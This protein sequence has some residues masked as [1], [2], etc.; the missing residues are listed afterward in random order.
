MN[1]SREFLG[2]RRAENYKE[3]VAD[4]LRSYQALG[5]GMSLRIP[6]FHSHPD[7]FPEHLGDVSDEHGERLYQD[8]AAMESRYHAGLVSI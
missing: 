4:M 6:F 5:A 1:V 7:F 2:S 8:I 3:G